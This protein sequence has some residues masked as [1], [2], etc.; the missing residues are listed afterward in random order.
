LLVI[1]AQAAIQL[2]LSLLVIPAEAGIQLLALI[3]EVQSF[4]SPRGRAG[5]FLA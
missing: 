1:S 2:L 4:V 5:Y 3:L